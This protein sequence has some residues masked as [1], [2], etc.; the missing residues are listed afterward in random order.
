MMGERRLSDVEQ[1]HE[2]ADAHLARV[3]AKHVDELQ[4]DRVAERLADLGHAQRLFALHVGVDDRLAAA[5][6]GGALLL[7][8]K[9]Q[10]DRDESTYIY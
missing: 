4:A 10:I 5:F 1:R 9:L 2:L 8:R 3:S 6:A 7:R